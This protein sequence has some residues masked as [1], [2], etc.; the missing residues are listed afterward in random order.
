MTD[1]EQI[2]QLKAEL[3]AVRAELLEHRKETYRSLIDIYQSLKEL[4][5]EELKRAENREAQILREWEQRSRTKGGQD[6]L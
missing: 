4:T 3:S 1:Q 2:Q 5:L 6:K